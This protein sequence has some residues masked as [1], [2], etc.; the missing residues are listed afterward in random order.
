MNIQPSP[1]E[2]DAGG[3]DSWIDD[4]LPPPSSFFP[5]TAYNDILDRVH[6]LAADAEGIALLIGV[7]GAG[8][9]TLLYRIQSDSPEH[10]ALCRVDANPML[11]PDQLLDRLARCID[12]PPLDDG[13]AESV[14]E[15]FCKLRLQGRLPVV[16]V[17]NAEQ[18]P[19]SSLMAL[20]RL[21]EQ[22]T[23]TAPACA[24][25]LL[26]QPDIDRTLTT[27]QLHAMGTARFVRL[28]LPRLAQDE[29]AEYV[30]HFL[31]ME[32]V[33]EELGFSP[34]QL[35]ALHSESG[36][37]PGK[38]N[39]LVI[40]ILR[41]AIVPRRDPLPARFVRWLRRI[42]QATALAT[43]VVALLL[44]LTLLFQ[45]QI[46][47]LFQEPA[48][49]VA[50]LP[51]LS[52]DQ[53]PAEPIREREER[54]VQPSRL[55]PFAGRLDREAEPLPHAPEPESAT[56]YE[57]EESAPIAENAEPEEVQAAAREPVKPATPRP[58][59][60]VL[61]VSAPKKPVSKPA[62]TSKP[63]HS[64]PVAAAPRFKREAWLLRQRP[65]A[66][67]LQILAAGSERSVRKF[68]QEHRL[69]TDVYYFK[70]QR[71][72]RPWIALLLGI[73]K[74][75][76]TAV[77]VLNMLP[78]SLRKAGAWPRSLASVQE[79]IKKGR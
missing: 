59:K 55:R 54:R 64:E 76:K 30:H 13:M 45:Q 50:S 20:L 43:G 46:D 1:I 71:G 51:E 40:R 66:Y 10:W 21:H 3:Q 9:T 31:R 47:S 39:E 69:T 11:H 61:P 17:D 34:Q 8:K 49:T 12:M 38:V 22:R 62:A 27:H 57:T 4:Q 33:E 36:G 24:L 53:R 29:T 28:E 52:H 44:L 41:D 58:P 63:V 75:R 26:A 37:L 7:Q 70:S 35:A 73:Y 74:D 25:I 72:G 65:E 23:A 77:T 6:R 14:A 15:A 60:A 19:I 18:L 16:M 5:G 78:D 67:S 68:A 42:P 56:R 48:P 79:E 2:P 32:G